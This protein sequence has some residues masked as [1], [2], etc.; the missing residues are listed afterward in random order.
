MEELREALLRFARMLA[1]EQW[2]GSWSYETTIEDK[3]EAAKA[4]TKASIGRELLRALG[5]EQ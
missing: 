4:E 2:S 5:E 1:A 3:I